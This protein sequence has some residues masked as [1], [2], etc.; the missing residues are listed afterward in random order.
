MVEANAEWMAWVEQ[1]IDRI[2]ADVVALAARASALEETVAA[3]RSREIATTV[4][5]RCTCPSTTGGWI[6]PT[7]CEVHSAQRVRSDG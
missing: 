3:L 6:V 4:D 7:T 2:H 1:H 5:A